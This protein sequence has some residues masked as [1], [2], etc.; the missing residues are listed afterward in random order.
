MK[1]QVSK[2]NIEKFSKV[3]THKRR[4]KEKAR[5]EIIRA[6]EEI[7][8]GFD[9]FSYRERIDTGVKNRAKIKTPRLEKRILGTYASSRSGYGFVVPEGQPDMRDIFI[10]EGESLGAIDGDFVECVYRQYRIGTGEAKTEG[11][12]VK[13][14]QAGRERIVGTLAVEPSYMRSKH[15]VPEVCYLIPDE[16]RLNIRP[17][18]KDM[19]C[20]RDGDKVEVTLFRGTGTGYSPFCAVERVFGTA[21]SREANYMAILS[22]SGIPLEFSE[23]ELSE[24]E[25]VAA[26]TVLDN[27]RKRYPGAVIFTIDGEGAKDL[28]DAV[29]I[30]K[31]KDGYRL[32]VHIADVSHYVK[33]NTALD[34]C[35][36]R[37]GTSV[38]FTDKVVPML[39]PVLSN[40]ACS[41]NAGEEKY[42]LSAIIDLN[43]EGEVVGLKIERSIISSR[44]RGVYSEV[45]SLF[46]GTANKALK[47]KYREVMPSLKKMHALYVLL[48]R[49]AR[50]RGA[51]ELE[52][53]EAEIVLG[54]SGEPIDILKRERGLGERMIEQFMLTA[55][56]AVAT[57]LSENR[58][59]CVYRVHEMPPVDKMREL[60]S[61]SKNLGLNISGIN[62]EEVKPKELSRL[63]SEAE[64]KGLLAKLSYTMLRSLSKAHYSDVRNGHFGLAIQNYC[65][66][67]SPI[68]RLSDLA[69][70]RIIKR[71]LLEKK[72]GARYKKYAARA[73]LVAS[74]TELVAVA[75]ER[76]IENLYKAVYM[77]GHIGE[78][79]A[80]VISSVTRFGLFAELDN[81]CEG[82]IPISEMP[83][84]F[85]FD[86]LHG[87]VFGSGLVFKVGQ[88]IRVKVCEVDVSRGK[89]KFSLVL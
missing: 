18:V 11:R 52:I 76:K 68:R 48:E 1:K 72:D 55:N 65:H 88:K 14:L 39:P 24:A 71:C 27:D 16:D 44:L 8:V 43:A 26:E 35:A 61:Y 28:D 85:S 47:E 6:L 64:E 66:F 38:Y 54:N 7:K 78:E 19:G 58:I 82:L 15:R 75:T 20:G 21:K 12:V 89:I 4:G 33:E 41:L 79:F 74:D 22:E 46:D 60:L 36:M 32:G 80:A 45:N 77:Q 81:T 83:G 49:K 40:G 13:I 29:S 37:R 51:L 56:E 73:A 57:L 67:T 87:T 34:R 2:R 63:L 62:A 42:A 17:I 30:K 23:A 50:L 25:N 84:V 9:G 70:H 3:N 59:P 10:P 5:R 53:P 31:R 69:T 86:E